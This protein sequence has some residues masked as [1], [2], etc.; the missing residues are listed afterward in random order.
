[1]IY[2]DINSGKLHF[3][4]SSSDESVAI[5][6]ELQY[7]IPGKNSWKASVSFSKSSYVSQRAHN[8]LFKAL[9][10]LSIQTKLEIADGTKY[11]CVI[12]S[13]DDL[14]DCEFIDIAS[15]NHERAS[16]VINPPKK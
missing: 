15:S 5:F 6:W 9:E 2:N 8:L 11:D 14:A 4:N 12:H 13:I 10:N 7:G 16:V 1:M 3:I